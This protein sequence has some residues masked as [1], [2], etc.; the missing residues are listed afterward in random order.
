MIK[1]VVV[2]IIS[3]LTHIIC[4]LLS[5]F[6]MVG[7]AAT[8]KKRRKNIF[9]NKKIK[10]VYIIIVLLSRLSIVCS[11]SRGRVAGVLSYAMVQTAASSR[12]RARSE[13]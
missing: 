9:S 3:I 11:V 5:P 13:L 8:N 2:S 4:I 7:S 10:I 12:T 6:T 1:I